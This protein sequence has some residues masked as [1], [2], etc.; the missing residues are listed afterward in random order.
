MLTTHQSCVLSHAYYTTWKTPD[1]VSSPVSDPISITNSP[2][3]ILGRISPLLL[4]IPAFQYSNHVSISHAKH[5]WAIQARV[6]TSRWSRSGIDQSY[7]W[8]CFRW[9]STLY[10]IIPQLIIQYRRRQSRSQP[11][12]EPSRQQYSH[13]S[14]W[15]AKPC[16]LA[17]FKS[18]CCCRT[19]SVLYSIVSH[20]WQKRYCLGWENKAQST[21][22]L[23]KFFPSGSRHIV[24][25][26][27]EATSLSTDSITVKTSH[28]I[29]EGLGE[30]LGNGE[31]RI[32]FVTAAIAT[33]SKY[34]FPSRP[35]TTNEEEN[36]AA[37]R[38]MQQEVK[39]SQSVLVIGGQFDWLTSNTWK[40]IPSVL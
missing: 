19:R 14:D 18:S 5:R 8:R 25:S 32:P 15:Y 3:V 36:K 31:Y 33:G 30:S 2:F 24:L 38:K 7:C 13:R 22:P 39:D 29:P 9:V 27:T 26:E 28:P 4:R 20:Y 21:T 35:A 37:L 12:E 10:L 40:L 17:Y 34:A 1:F 23:N 16:L 6:K 11:R